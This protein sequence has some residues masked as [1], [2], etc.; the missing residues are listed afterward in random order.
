MKASQLLKVDIEG[1]VNIVRFDMAT[2]QL[3][4]SI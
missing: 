4:M 1:I 3:A 2:K